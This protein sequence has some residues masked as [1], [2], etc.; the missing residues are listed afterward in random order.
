VGAC[1]VESVDALS[2]LR[3]WDE[4]AGR[5]AAGWPRLPLALAAFAPDWRW[6]AVHQLWIGPHD[7]TCQESREG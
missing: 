3:D 4:T 6:D 5:I 2:G 1:S 7:A